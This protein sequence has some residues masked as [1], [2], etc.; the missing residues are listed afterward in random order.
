VRSL[1]YFPCFDSVL[2]LVPIFKSLECVPM[3][4]R[5]CCEQNADVCVGAL[6]KTVHSLR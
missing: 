2:E 1:L 5:R 6:W 4:M 3:P